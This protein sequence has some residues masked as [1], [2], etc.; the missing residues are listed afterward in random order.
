MYNLTNE[1]VLGEH[2]L[3]APNILREQVFRLIKPDG[4]ATN[5]LREQCANGDEHAVRS[6]RTCCANGG[7]VSAY[8]A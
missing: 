5:M 8:K 4:R 6:G 1:R 7:C 3:Q 2:A